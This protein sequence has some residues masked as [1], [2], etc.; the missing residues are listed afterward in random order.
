MRARYPLSSEAA[1]GHGAARTMAPRCGPLS[2]PTSKKKAASAPAPD[3]RAAA[4]AG[5]NLS[6]RQRVILGATLLATVLA[7][8]P[9]LRNGWVFDDWVEIVNNHFIGTWAFVV[10]SLTHDCLW[11]Y[12]PA[13]LPQSPYYRPLQD[14]SLALGYFLFGTHPAGWHAAGIALHLIGV[15]LAFR[16]AQLLTGETAMGLLAAAIFAVLP[17][18]VEAVAWTS[19]IP[20][21]LVAIFEM[22]ALCCFIRRKAGWSRGL[23]LALAFY[24][25]A[26]LTHESAILFPLIIAGYVFLLEAPPAPPR[27]GRQRSDSARTRIRSSIRASVP[28]LALAVAYL[29]VR[30]AVLGLHGAVRVHGGNIWTRLAGA[31]HLAELGTPGGALWRFIGTAPV[32]ILD[33][34]ATLAIPGFAGPAH[35]VNWIAGVSAPTILAAGAIIALASLAFVLARRSPDRRLYAFCALWAL[36]ALAPAMNLFEIFSLVQ[37]RSLYAPSFGFCL[38]MAVVAV[39]AARSWPRAR[40]PVAAAMALLLAGYMGSTVWIQHYFYD[41]SAFFGRCITV[42]P[43]NSGY[44][45][46]LANFQGTRGDYRGVAV[47]YEALA[48]QFPDDPQIHK[49]LAEAYMKLGRVADA[50]AEIAKSFALSHEKAGSGAPH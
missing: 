28:F 4:V 11:Y 44:R 16:L 15:A 42:N 22:A 27:R 24:G 5:W 19:A 34:M 30:V 18:H 50:Q 1:A 13:H 12:D 17:A 36:I 49:S 35:D 21:P 47:Q 20:E 38:A 14:L 41:N 45:F 43:G 33:Y 23:T 9:S 25:C 40:K 26:L 39:R 10:K 2:K 7:Y 48:R 3:P 6:G 32:V 37:D 29:C 8:L 31:G 46:A